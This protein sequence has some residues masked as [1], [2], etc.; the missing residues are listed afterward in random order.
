MYFRRF[1]FLFI[2][3]TFKSYSRLD[4]VL[5]WRTW[6]NGWSRTCREGVMLLLVTNKQHQ[7]SGWTTRCLLYI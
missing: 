3:S 7:N 1:R 6:W 2:W 4:W 5:L